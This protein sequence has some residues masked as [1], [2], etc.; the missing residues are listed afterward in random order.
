[1]TKRRCSFEFFTDTFFCFFILRTKSIDSCRPEAS[2]RG[3][4]IS[5]CGRGAAEGGAKSG[6]QPH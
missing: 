5:V 6:R 2:G 1:M 3:K 4:R